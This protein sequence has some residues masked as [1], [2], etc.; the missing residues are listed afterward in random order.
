[1]IER[2]KVLA[3]RVGKRLKDFPEAWQ[4]YQ[5]W[6]R[7][8]IDSHAVLRS[9]HPAWLATLIFRWRLIYFVIYV[10]S[11]LVT[12]RFQRTYLLAMRAVGQ[13]K[14]LPKDLDER[15]ACRSSF[16]ILRRLATVLAVAEL[17]LCGLATFTGVMLAFYYE[18][19]A[20]GAHRSLS[21]IATQIPNGALILS[22]HDIAGNGLI[23]LTLVQLVVMFLGR[24]FL[25][26]WLVAWVSGILL[27]LAAIGLSWTAIVL[28]WDQIGFWRFKIELSIVETIP[29]IGPELRELLSGGGGISSLT[30]QHMYTLHSYLLA[31]A[32]L[33]LS[34]THL[35]ALILQEQTWKPKEVRLQLG[36][37]CQ[38][39]SDKSA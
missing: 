20:V 9:Q 1:M 25:P 23:V 12:Q 36:Q 19:T 14:D 27:A 30:L 37:P 39:T 24:Q 28:N 33:L 31:I 15:T 10:G 34:I 2:D 35:T 22:L 29:L 32:A 21:A 8:I 17:T 6:L 5:D 11:I 26:S 4:S 3:G 16:S 7:E 13:P 18:S 38:S